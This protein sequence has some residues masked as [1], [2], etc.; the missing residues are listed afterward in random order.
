MKIIFAS[1]ACFVVFIIPQTHAQTTAVTGATALS[2]MRGDI[3]EI[4]GNVGAESKSIA[5]EIAGHLH[6]LI[7]NLEA[8]LGEK[9]GKPIS[10]LSQELQYQVS[11]TRFLVRQ[12]LTTLND[13]P[14][15]VGNETQMVL[16]SFKSGIESAKS[17]IP[18]I[19]KGEPIFYFSKATT[20]RQPYILRSS[21]ESSV[22]NIQGA[23]LWSSDKVCELSATATSV[24]TGDKL[25]LEVLGHDIES[26]KLKVP[27]GL[28]IGEYTLDVFVQPKGF[29]G[30]CIFPSER[31][32]TTIVDIV[33]SPKISYEVV[34]TP[35]CKAYKGHK[36]NCSGGVNAGACKSGKDNKSYTCRFD[37]PGI[38]LLNY[39]YKVTKNKRGGGKA[40]RVGND[41]RVD[42]QASHRKW[43]CSKGTG[44]YYWK[45][46]MNGRSP[47]PDKRVAISKSKIVELSPGTSK[48]FSLDNSK[49]CELT[50][51]VVV[52][53]S[54]ET[55]MGSIV[56]GPKETSHGGTLTESEGPIS[57][58]WAPRT[59]QGKIA[60]SEASCISI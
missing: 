39:D 13:L 9:V 18:L 33:E 55:N 23:N 38:S 19:G 29:L 21:Q 47:L 8:S 2:L 22:V 35:F 4:V 28:G 52:A 54:K 7:D 12:A 15:C 14:G 57:M 5:G 20:S 24:L 50:K 17:N 48:P 60:M 37:T 36:K 32:L 42:Y 16:A 49:G 46:T 56:V 58:T 41:V 31:K 45:L 3:D 40:T 43:D 59:G 34:A 11:S 26:F 1:L 44:S 27:G 30:N 6:E 25:D 51:W 10:E 53:Q